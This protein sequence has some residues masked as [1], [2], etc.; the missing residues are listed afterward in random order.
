MAQ[1][2]PVAD[3][4]IVEGLVDLTTFE[5]VEQIARCGSISAAAAALGVSQQAASERL[6][7]AERLLGHPLVRRSISGSVLTDQGAMVL[8][9]A[10]PVLAAG[11]RA[12]A[13][14]DALRRAEAQLAVA[15]SQTVAEFLLPE[16]LQELRRL[17]PDAVVRLVSGNSED[18][19][20]RVRA[21]SAQ[22][23]FIESPAAP[24]DL[25]SMPVGTDELLVVTAPGHPWT[26]VGVLT[27]EELAATPLLVREV[28]SGT[29]AT[30]E[31]WLGRRGLAL[32]A[33]AAELGTTAAIR[34]AAAAGVAPAVLSGLAVREQLARH[35]LEAVRVEEPAPRRR[36]AAL[37]ADPQPGAVA[38]ALL[39]IARRSRGGSGPAL[40]RR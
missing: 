2:E 34:A 9:W 25:A 5:L 7:R 21:G 19:V 15:A 29:R 8:E 16:W 38:S 35:L 20:A 23:G 11:R 39:D 40:S 32:A 28:G 1:S 36:F 27:A 33:P 24:G 6:R 18:V 4:W 13:S 30:L 17:E 31:D 12:A 22:L 37:W 14:I 10:A 26:R 3:R